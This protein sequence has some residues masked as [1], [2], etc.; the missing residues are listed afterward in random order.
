MIPAIAVGVG[1]AISAWAGP[2]TT[3]PTPVSDTHVAKLQAMRNSDVKWHGTYVGLLPEI[4]DNELRGL[5][6]TTEAIDSILLCALTD[7]DRM[8]VAHVLLAFRHPIQRS[9]ADE[10]EQWQGLS[11]QLSANGEATYHRNNPRKLQREWAH[12]LNADGLTCR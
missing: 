11:V 2:S 10:A 4:L 6:D 8:A 9:P 1:L 5:I 7:T 12:A 3:S